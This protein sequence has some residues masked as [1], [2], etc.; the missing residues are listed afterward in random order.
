MEQH[1]KIYTQRE[2]AEAI[3]GLARIKGGMFTFSHSPV[4][5]NDQFI[6]MVSC[7][8]D[9]TKVQSLEQMIRKEISAKGF[10]AKHTFDNILGISPQLSETIEM[11]KLYAKAD[12]SVLIEGES[13][14]GKEL[15]AQSIHNESARSSGPFV[16]IN[17][18][19]IPENLLESELFGYETGAFTGAKKD[20]KAGLF[21]L[22]HGG[23]LFLDE[24]GEITEAVQARLLRVLQEKE[25]MRVGGNKVIP[26]NVRVISA[27]NRDLWERTQEGAFRSDLYYRLNVLHL[28]IPPLR[29]RT[30]DIE[31]LSKCF[32]NQKHTIL[33]P[34]FYSEILPRLE[35]HS[36][37]G[38]VRELE[39]VMERYS[40]L[41]TIWDSANITE[42]HINALLSV[43]NKDVN[44]IAGRTIPFPEGQD[45]KEMV[46]NVEIEI[47]H[48]VLENCGNSQAEAAR[49]L[50]IGRTTL[51]RKLN[52]D[53]NDDSAKNL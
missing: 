19:S 26:I 21:E 36:W 4:K 17:C 24:I 16:A 25:I 11:A 20:G 6:G 37:P 40:L 3:S 9:I 43:T 39:S 29:N 45:L 50:G 34:I 51:W 7:Y 35:H 46:E 30:G 2:K 23:T 13:G 44:E 22:A 28:N 18:T 53:V 31:E 33:N 41:S 48:R 10:K 38:N 49:R 32:A 8:E 47:I 15:F 14:T 5:L 42:T 52:H 1:E 27:T 12:S